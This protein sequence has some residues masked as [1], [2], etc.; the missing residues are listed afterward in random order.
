MKSYEVGD[1]NI[2]ELKIKNVNTQAEVNPVDQV[3]FID[4]YEDFNSPSLY[5]EISFNDQVGLL[6]DFPLIGEEEIEITFQTPGLTYPTTY[7]FNSFAISDLQQNMN[8]KG[9]TYTLKCTSKEQLKQS[10]I[11][12]VQSYNETIDSV[13]NN[14]FSR[15]LQ[16]DKILDIDPCKGTETIV[17]PKLTPFMSIDMVRKRAV[18]PKFVSSLYVFFENQEGFKFK[19]IEQ[20]IEDGKQK[21]GS[22]K[23]YYYSSTQISKETEALSFRSILEY[24][25]MARTDVTDIVQEGGIKNK[26][27]V[28][29]VF[30]KKET[31]TEFDLTKKFSSMVSMDNKN[32]L[33]ISDTAIQ[34]FANK[35]TYNFFIPKDTNRKENFLENMMGAKLA[36][37][38]IFNSNSVRVY[39]PGDSS[40]KAGDV[41]ELNLPQASGTTSPKSDDILVG[42]NYIV[43]RLRHNITTSGKAKHYI[44]MDCNKVG[45][46]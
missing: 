28:F 23:F 38:K 22:K 12:I 16:T 37:T 5:A 7:K 46:R 4:I 40:I 9:Y 33:N 8:G 36:F 13:V 21:I 18:N 25:N 6:N 35:P 42:G 43:T 41:V 17:F 20:M 3:T 2:L 26:V 30:T 45:L 1:V 24:E 10:N 31:V 15:Y 19:C 27:K 32:S 14:I 44:S 39:I 34:Q 11:F 29:D